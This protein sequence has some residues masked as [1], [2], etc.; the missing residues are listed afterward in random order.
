MNPYPPAGAFFRRTHGQAKDLL[1]DFATPS[2]RGPAG[3]AATTTRSAPEFQPTCARAPIGDK[4]IEQVAGLDHETEPKKIALP[5]P[6][7]V[8]STNAI[9]VSTT[10][11]HRVSNSPTDYK[12]AT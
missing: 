10:L 4:G 6:K 9:T 7:S 8:L 3:H 11:A 2:P 1:K 12:K 5:L